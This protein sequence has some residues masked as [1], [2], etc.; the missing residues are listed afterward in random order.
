M[1]PCPKLILRLTRLQLDILT[2]R[3]GLSFRGL[4]PPYKV[5]VRLAGALLELV[6]LGDGGGLS[7]LEAC[8]EVFFA[9][10]GTSLEVVGGFLGLGFAPAEPGPPG[11]L[12]LFSLLS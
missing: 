12:G 11:A 5:I 9:F 1:N 8:T 10:A 6:A 4:E 2:L 3:R 7:L